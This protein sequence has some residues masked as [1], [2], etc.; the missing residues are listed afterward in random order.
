MFVVQLCTHEAMP[1]TLPERERQMTATGIFGLFDTA[2]YKFLCA[3][4]VIFYA[5]LTFNN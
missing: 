5:P 3:K 4:D 2:K 1:E